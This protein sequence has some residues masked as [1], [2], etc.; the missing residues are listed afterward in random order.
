MSYLPETSGS[1]PVRDLRAL[2][3]ETFSV[4][5][6]NFWYFIGIVALVQLPL[7]VLNL[8]PGGVG[9]SIVVT[10][11]AILANLLVNGAAISAVAQQYTGR[12]NIDIGLCYFRAW[13]RMPILIPM[14]IIA[15]L[16]VGASFIVIAIIAAQVVRGPIFVIIGTPPPIYFIVVWFFAAQAI[17]ME[18]I[19]PTQSLRR[20]FRLVQ[21]S[22]WRVFGIG[23]VFFL[24]TIMVTIP[25]LIAIAIATAAEATALSDILSV[26]LNAA[27]VIFAGPLSY[28]G[29]TLVYYDL[30]V[31]KEG[32]TFVHM[33]QELGIVGP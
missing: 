27:A 20:S 33:S 7:A 29:A 9:L 13:K 14:V 22:W 28:I 21:A 11:I 12:G 30:R 8:I 1:P 15:A 3:N 16:V 25:F 5:G 10:I 4:Y 18:G 6:R 32:Y 23:I 17:I 31:R 19:G 2:I 26:V 24:I